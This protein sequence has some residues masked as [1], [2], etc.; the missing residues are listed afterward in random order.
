MHRLGRRQHRHRS[1][2][3]TMVELIVVMMIIA[4][5]FYAVRPGIVRP[6]QA[7]R[8]RAGLRRV[9]GALT[10][11]RAKAV[12][13]GRL[14]RVSVAPREGRLWAEMQSDPWR[15][16]NAFEPLSLLGK[17]E[18]VV[19][20][21]LAVTSLEIGGGDEWQG[22]EAAINFYPDGRATSARLVLAGAT[23]KEFVVELLPATGRVRV[24]M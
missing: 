8:E 10:A 4:I 5:A 20:E 13:E 19:P 23:G 2:G 1:R 11:A 18:T 7:N 21:A 16:R 12:A 3:F 14:V 15:D 24:E 6:L 22:D 17:R 9:V